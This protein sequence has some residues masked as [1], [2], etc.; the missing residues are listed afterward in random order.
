[1]DNEKFIEFCKNELVQICNANAVD[2]I[3]T[4]NVFVVW[5]CKALQNNKAL[6]AAN[7][8]NHCVYYEFTHNGDKNKTYIDIYTKIENLTFKH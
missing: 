2:K 1:M 8:P 5:S 3:T 6:L 4:D 7:I